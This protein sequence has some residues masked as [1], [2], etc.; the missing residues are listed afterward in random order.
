[1]HHIID[2]F[3]V[4]ESSIAIT[5]PIPIPILPLLLFDMLS[6]FFVR[7]DFSPLW[8]RHTRKGQKQDG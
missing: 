8:F 3:T 5:V 6:P 2:L 4:H 7:G 1:M